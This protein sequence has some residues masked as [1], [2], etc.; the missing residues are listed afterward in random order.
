MVRYFG[1]QKW[2]NITAKLILDKKINYLKSKGFQDIRY[3]DLWGNAAQCK[4][5]P[6][7]I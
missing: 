6:N 1:R 5:R 7:V 2:F 4:L 3:I